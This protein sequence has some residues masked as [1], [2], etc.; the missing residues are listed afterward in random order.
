MG[1]EAGRAETKGGMKMED[2]GWAD[3]Y[4]GPGEY[5]LWEGRPG[6]GALV[7]R[8][9]AFLIPFSL[10]WC[11]FVAFWEL[12]ALR[13]GLAL[14]ALWGIPFIL[15]GAYLLFGRFLVEASRRR[16]ARYAITTE[17]VLIWE[18]GRLDALSRKE[19]PA[20][21][22]RPGKDGRGTILLGEPVYWRQGVG[23]SRGWRYGGYPY[24]L[25]NI[26]DVDRVWRMLQESPRA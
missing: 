23:R 25:K 20:V 6:P 22:L 14:F 9:D 26:A 11:G 24:Q 18:R 8:E 15:V 4:L 7:G 13:Q 3:R 21:H 10:A 12:T 19:L 1:R 2:Y 17:K 5:V 16:G